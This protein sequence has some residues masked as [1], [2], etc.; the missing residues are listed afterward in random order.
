MLIDDNGHDNFFHERVIRK[1]DVC[2]H[3]VVQKKAVDALNYL[4]ARIPG[5]AD[6]PDLILLDINMPGMNGWDFLEQFKQLDKGKQATMVVM[7]TTSSNPDDESRART[8]GIIFDFR[9]KPL[10]KAM[11]EEI[12]GNFK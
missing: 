9:S 1:A 8:T 4:K 6:Y 5:N 2:N 12:I 11:L 3:V 10:T 7:L